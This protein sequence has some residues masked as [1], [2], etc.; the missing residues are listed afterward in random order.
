MPELWW[1]EHHF[2]MCSIF[3]EC[4]FVLTGALV[5]QLQRVWSLKGNAQD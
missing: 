5:P 1:K 3:G 4:V 2:K